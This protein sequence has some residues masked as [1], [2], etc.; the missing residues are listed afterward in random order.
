HKLLQRK[1]ARKNLEK[2]ER[3]HNESI[4]TA[5]RR[6]T[7]GL[8]LCRRKNNSSSPIRTTL[9]PNAKLYAIPYV[10]FISVGNKI[11]NEANC[12]RMMDV[13][14]A[15]IKDAASEANIGFI[16]SIQTAFKGHEMY[17]SDPYVDDFFA[18][19]NAAHPNAKGYAKIGQL[20]AAYLQSQ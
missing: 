19:K 17:S 8:F 4:T 10:D 3:R 20:V 15:T 5:R 2:K 16:D 7:I 6:I 18:S 12:H 1:R 13:L 9:N 14:T 11:P